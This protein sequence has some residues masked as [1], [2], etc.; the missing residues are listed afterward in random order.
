MSDHVALTRPESKI[1]RDGFG[2]YLSTTCG[3][4]PEALAWLHVVQ[5]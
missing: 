1:A 4:W 3:G 2:L 5:A